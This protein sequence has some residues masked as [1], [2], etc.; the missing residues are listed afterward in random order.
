MYCGIMLRYTCI[1]YCRPCWNL[2]I[3]HSRRSIVCWWWTGSCRERRRCSLAEGLMRWSGASRA[4]QT[5]RSQRPHSV[6]DWHSTP[7][8][9]S[10]YCTSRCSPRSPSSAASNSSIVCS[11]PRQQQHNARTTQYFTWKSCSLV[12]RTKSKKRCKQWPKNWRKIA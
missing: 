7:D 6:I 8:S 5:S 1:I 11:L 4:R 2:Y 9:R 3:A 10:V 12:D